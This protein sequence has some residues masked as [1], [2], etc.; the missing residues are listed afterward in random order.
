M[1]L[2]LIEWHTRTTRGWDYDVWHGGRFLEEWADAKTLAELKETYGRYDRSE[3]CSA[4]LAS[5][6]EIVSSIGS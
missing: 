4:L 5:Y 6:F 3:M 1:L 2:Q